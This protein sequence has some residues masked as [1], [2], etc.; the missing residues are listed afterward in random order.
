MKKKEY[1]KIETQLI[2]VIHNFVGWSIKRGIIDMTDIDDYNSWEFAEMY[3]DYR[4]SNIKT[5]GF[6]YNKWFGTKKQDVIE[7]IKNNVK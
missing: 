2:N 7:Y 5:R 3:M 6:D 4:I 1:T